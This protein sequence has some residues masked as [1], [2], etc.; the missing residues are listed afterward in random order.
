MICHQEPTVITASQNRTLLSPQDSDP[1]GM[2]KPKLGSNLVLM[3]LG[4][5]TYVGES[6]TC[7]YIDRS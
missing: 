2:G 7:G 3:T 1:N 6:A 4:I 5:D